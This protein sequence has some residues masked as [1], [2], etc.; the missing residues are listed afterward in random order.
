LSR[1]LRE[2]ALA[3]TIQNK[4]ERAYRRGDDLE[5]RREMMQAWANWC[6]SAENRDDQAVGFRN[7]ETTEG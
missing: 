3:H 4:T 6:Y 7:H 5:K 1:E 2:T